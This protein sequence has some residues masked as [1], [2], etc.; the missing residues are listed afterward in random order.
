MRPDL[1]TTRSSALE[2][3]GGDQ[4]YPQSMGYK[5]SNRQSEALALRAAGAS[6]QQIADTLGIAKA[7]AHRLVQ[8]GLPDREPDE[9]E[10]QLDLVRLDQALMA[11]WPQVR[12]GDLAAV[13]TFVKLTDV[14]ERLRARWYMR[15]PNVVVNTQTNVS[16]DQGVL[17][18]QGDTKESYIAGLRRARGEQAA[19]PAPD[20]S[21]DDLLQQ[22]RPADQGVSTVADAGLNGEI[23]VT[24]LVDQPGDLRGG[25]ND[26]EG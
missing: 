12:T 10:L 20:R 6:Y 26:I 11:I 16:S 18:I 2:H 3:P 22:D 24:R 19:L 23:Q 1:D 4:P 14:R 5:R 8:R 21:G 7:T 17:V 9:Q 25:L 15:G 13:N